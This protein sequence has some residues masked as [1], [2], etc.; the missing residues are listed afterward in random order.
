MRTTEELFQKAFEHSA[1]GMVIVG[2]DGVPVFHNPAMVRML[3]YSE[4]EFS[5]LSVHD[6]THPDDIGA[7]IEAYGKLRAGECDSYTLDKRFRKADGTWLW[8]R[9]TVSMLNA[10]PEGRSHTLTVVHDISSEKEAE[11][12]LLDKVDEMHS[13]FRAIPDLC[14]RVDIEGRILAYYANRNPELFPHPSEFMGRS[15]LEYLPPEIK[16]RYVASMRQ[17]LQS[18][19]MSVLEYEANTR[20]GLRFFES[21]MVPL[22]AG[23]AL[24]VVRDVTERKRLEL[25]QIK[26]AKLES[27]AVLAGGMAHDFNNLLTAVLGNVSLAMRAEGLAEATRQRLD[28]TVT[29]V[30]RAR[31]LTQ[32][33]LTFSKGGSPPLKRAVQLGAVVQEAAQL[34][35]QGSASRLQIEIAADLPMVMA[36]EEQI[37]R[38]VHNLVLNAGQAMPQGGTV[39][40][41]VEKQGGELLVTVRD[42]GCG[43]SPQNLLRVF[44]PY[45]T[46]KDTGSGLGLTTAYAIV[47]NHDGHIEVESEPGMGTTF[48]VRLPAHGAG[49]VEECRDTPSPQ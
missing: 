14:F 17:M 25:E 20:A 40:V 13:L 10:G 43:I 4:E 24:V 6:V 35:A 11:R 3:G 46:T 33:L 5:R 45:F 48:R 39:L 44:D 2:Q 26:V 19:K 30:R 37:S 23:E 8:G 16:S 12:R 27:L 31:H 32:Q 28:D 22:A 34:A 41:K 49:G 29:A 18:G 1:V 36:D 38:V 15:A 42:E 9:V 47:R 21:Q 7:N